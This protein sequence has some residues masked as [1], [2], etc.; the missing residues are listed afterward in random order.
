MTNTTLID[1]RDLRYLEV[2]CP[3]CHRAIVFDLDAKAELPEACA[4]CDSKF[5][6]AARETLTLSQ[7]VYQLRHTTATARFRVEGAAQ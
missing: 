6:A 1:L 3:Q 2:G 7:R 4:G 5:D